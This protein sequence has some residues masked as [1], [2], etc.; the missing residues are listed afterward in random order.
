MGL[1]R[2]RYEQLV[3]F[4]IISSEQSKAEQSAGHVDIQQAFVD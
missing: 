2:Q 4:T 3:P 1:C